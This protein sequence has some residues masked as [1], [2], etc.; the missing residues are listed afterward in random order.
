MDLFGFAELRVVTTAAWLARDLAAGTTVPV[1]HDYGLDAPADTSRTAWWA[2]HRFIARLMVTP[3]VTRPHLL[4]PGP[5]WLTTVDEQWTGRE[6]WAGQLAAI[7]GCPLWNRQYANGVRVFAKAA[8][9]KRDLLPARA[10]G[11]AS[12]FHGT[13]ETAGLLPGSHVVLSEVVEFTAEYRCFIAP[14]TDG[15]PTVAAAS[16]YLVDGQTWDAWENSQDAPD[17]TEAARFAQQVVATVDGPPGY[18]LDVGRLAD[19]T[20]A[21][22]E[23]NASWSSNPYHCDPAGVVASILAAQDPDGDQRWVWGSDPAIDRFARPLPVRT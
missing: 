1:V 15:A 7:A 18:V 13:A 21:V 23:A 10:Y 9:I 8:E 20:W 16:A 2:P 6:L 14:G 17:P 19:G 12:G 5:A 3:G 22:V 11:T 4:S